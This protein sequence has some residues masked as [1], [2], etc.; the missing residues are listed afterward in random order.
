[1]LAC[2]SS[3]FAQ[4]KSAV[5][6]HHKGRLELQTM[7]DVLP[8]SIYMVA[9]SELSHPA[10]LYNMMDD[11]LRANDGRSGF[12]LERKLLANFQ[13][14]LIFTSQEWEIPKEAT[15]QSLT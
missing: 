10:S 14:A 11:Y 1:M 12:D 6:D 4:L 7:D 9:M 8:L 2:L 5:V 3:A 15:A 13:G